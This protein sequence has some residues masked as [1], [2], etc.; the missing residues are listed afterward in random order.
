MEHQYAINSPIDLTKNSELNMPRNKAPSPT[1]EHQWAINSAIDLTK[2]SKLSMP[3]NKAPSRLG[4]KLP[5][6]T[7]SQKLQAIIRIRNGET[8]ASVSRD[9]GVP[10]STLRGW[11][12][13]A[14]KLINQALIK[15]NRNLERLSSFSKSNT[16]ESSS[17]SPLTNLTEA[18]ISTDTKESSEEV[19]PHK[20]SMKMDNDMLSTSTS[21]T[22]LS[23]IKQYEFQYNSAILSL[24]MNNMLSNN[25]I[26][27]PQILKQFYDQQV[28]INTNR[29]FNTPNLLEGSGYSSLGSTNNISFAN[30]SMMDSTISNTMN[31]QIDINEKKTRHCGMLTSQGSTFDR[32]SKRQSLSPT[33]ERVN[34]SVPSTSSRIVNGNNIGSTMSKL[35]QNKKNIHDITYQLLL[36]QQ[37]RQQQQ[38]K[39]VPANIN[40]ILPP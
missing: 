28:L 24:Q 1:M 18:S 5:L 36:R 26:D 17:C 20:K 37:S 23:S 10:E 40:S 31:S 3:R 35:S 19:E 33:T 34:N 16:P 13:A 4:R 2:D 9:I 11:C 32:I 27:N 25:M 22:S 12:K 30:V 29:I 39:Q 38:L 21:S 15:N 6:R 8:K 14:H 7:L